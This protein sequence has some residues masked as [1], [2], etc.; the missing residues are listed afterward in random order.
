MPWMRK[1]VPIAVP[2]EVSAAVLL[3]YNWGIYGVGCDYKS[4]FVPTGS[5]GDMLRKT[6]EFR[7]EVGNG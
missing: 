3:G 4:I 6:A 2:I 1:T 7:S 5:R